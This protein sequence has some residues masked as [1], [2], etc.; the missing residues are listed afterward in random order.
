[1]QP[2]HGICAKL[3]MYHTIHDEKHKKEFIYTLKKAMQAIP[4]MRC[5]A[6]HSISLAGSSMTRKSLESVKQVST[7]DKPIDPHYVRNYGMTNLLK[8]EKCLQNKKK[9]GFMNWLVRRVAENMSFL[10]SILKILMMTS[11]CWSW[12]I[13]YRE[14]EYSNQH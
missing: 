1:M 2:S 11:I 4:N 10:F 8:V 14:V 7:K 9:K 6:L 3:A 12:W 13:Q 5:G